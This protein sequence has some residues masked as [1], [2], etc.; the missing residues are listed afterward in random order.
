VPVYYEKGWMF[1]V[2][3]IRE[4][5]SDN[6]GDYDVIR[7]VDFIDMPLISV[8]MSVYNSE[9]FLHESIN[10]I[11]EQ[12]FKNF[13]F[14]IIN[15]GSNDNSLKI[16]L[17]YQ[18][19]D[20]RILIIDQNNIGLTKSLNRGIKLSRCKYIARQDA[21]DKS[22]PDR[23]K[24]Q[25][26]FFEN[27]K[28][29]FLVGCR[30]NIIDESGHMI[31]MPQMPVPID[32]SEIR[33]VIDKYNPFI[34]SFVMFRK[35]IEKI[36][37]FYNPRYRYSQDIELWARIRDYYKM[38][39]LPEVLGLSRQWPGMISEKNMKLQRRYGLKRKKRLIFRSFFDSGFWFYLIKDL[40][41][42]YLPIFFRRIYRGMIRKP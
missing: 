5:L 31:G 42:A 6:D 33:K 7:P 18:K 14:I 34:H 32:D 25:I 26:D 13:E 41:V 36:G 1:E 21:D 4:I 10:S 8:V 24:M 39:N 19:Y 15:D 28:D 20:N 16:L 38:H 23:L 40:S 2:E 12:S 3:L 27:N 17:E 29:H 37:Y 35:D 22:L 30:H 9:R 11:I